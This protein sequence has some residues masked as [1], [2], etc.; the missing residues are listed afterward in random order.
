[1]QIAG[2]QSWQI[3]IDVPEKLQ[4]A[5]YNGQHEGFGLIEPAVAATPDELEWRSWWAAMVNGSAGGPSRLFDLYDPPGFASLS[6]RPLVR[7]LCLRHW[8]AFKPTWDQTKRSAIQRMMTGMNEVD[9]PGIVRICEQRATTPAP[10]VFTLRLDFVQW[11]D[12]YARVVSQ[13]HIVLGMG[14]LEPPRLSTLRDLLAARVAAL[15]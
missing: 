11:A 2:T 12:E 6:S 14:Y 5:T 9:I 8:A 3:A 7:T 10:H 1:M 4:F 15:L 13:D